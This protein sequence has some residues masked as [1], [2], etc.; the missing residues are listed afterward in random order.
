M[1]NAS[2]SDTPDFSQPIAALRHCHDRIRKELLALETLRLHVMTNGA[3]G[4]A[5]QIATALIRYFDHAAPIHH[6]DEE[7]DL[8]P[9]LQTVARDAD[10][11]LLHLM[12]PALMRDHEEMAQTW[13]RVQSSLTQIATGVATAPDLGQVKQFSLLYAAHMDT[14]ETHI[15][16]MAR[17]LLDPA[18]MQELGN[19][20]RARRGIPASPAAAAGA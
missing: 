19:A 7:I 12:V 1:N 9:L 16:T 2:P 14:E 10:A 6:A 20:M 4:H 3:D 17:R 15:A 5:R 11:A 13:Q 18:Q 8:I